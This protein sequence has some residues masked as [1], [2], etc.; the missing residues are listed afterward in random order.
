MRAAVLW[1]AGALLAVAPGLALA[2]IGDYL[3]KPVASLRVEVE[4]RPVSDPRVVGLIET[5][6]GSPLSMLAVRETI[7]HLF[8]LGRY[9][10]VRVE[11]DGVP[12]GVRLTYDLV[13]IHPIEKILFAGP[14]AQPGIDEGRLRRAVVERYGA[15]PQA[16]RRFDL[17]RIV[18]EELRQR[19]YLRAT[20]APTIEIAHAP[21]RAT[22]VFTIEPGV[23]THV[24]TI[25]VV[26]APGVPIPEFLNRLGLR[27]GVSYERDALN[28]RIQEYQKGQWSGGYV[29]AKLAVSTRLDDDDRTA[30]LTL[31]VSRGPR[32]RVVFKG[33]PIARDKHAELV[34]IAEEASADEDLLEDSTN[35]IEEYLRGLGYRDAAAPHERDEV[36][37][38]LIITFT[39]TRGPLYRVSEVVISGNR[40]ESLAQLEPRFAVH[41]GQPFAQAK[42][43]ADVSAIE[44]F[45]R[46]QGFAA[47]R[48]VPS[49]ELAPTVAG[50][51]VP[52]VVRLAITEGV[53]TVVGSVHVRGNRSV[54]EVELVRG[55]GLQPGS[56]FFLTQMAIDRDAL[57]LQYAN[58]GYQSATIASNP[59]IDV[60]GG[61]ANVVFT[62]NEGPQLIVDHVL[63]VGNMRTK[64][65]TIER[66]L[67][68]KAG[69][70]VGLAAV[71]ESQRRLA[72]L[73]LFR[74]VRIMQV[75]HG[76]EA[77]RDLVVTIEESPVTTVGYG[78][79][80]E[81]LQRARTDPDSGAAVEHLEFSPR[82][83]FE[84]GRRNLFG[85][86]RSIN[87]FMRISLRPDPGQS[88]ADTRV[89]FSEYRVFGA[90]REPRLFGTAADA[91]L[92]GTIEQQSRS[93]FNF[94]RQVFSVELGRRVTPNVSFSG[95]YQIQRSELFDQGAIAEEDKL[96]IDRLFPQ[97]L[98]S[99]FSASGVQST[100]DD[101]VNPTMGHY[102]SA[103]GQLAARVIGSEVGF[104]KSY[105]TAQ[106]FRTLPRSRGTVLATSARLG[107]AYGFPR[108]I[109][110][111]H[112]QG[113]PVPGPD[114]A[115]GFDLVL[116]L[117]ASER[118]FAGGDTTVRGFALDQLGTPATL[119]SNGFAIGGNAVLILNA[120]LRVPIHGSIGVVG[121]VDAGNVFARTSDI[122]LGQ[123]RSTLGFGVRYKSP[124]GPIRVDIG[125]KT[126]RNE[127]VPGRFESANS[128]HISLGQAF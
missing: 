70:P 110:R 85:K 25:D 117:P 111:T 88:T 87:L 69:D 99:S 107:M 55:L 19:G 115:P 84:V 48:V 60:G 127:L 24:G 31:T 39:V 119:D 112:E 78:G 101:A 18:E 11:A 42:L 90:F 40:F 41:K 66:E 16:G 3:G 105:L 125:F 109:E 49:L 22:L 97:V 67:Q 63:I 114:G 89:G 62:V 100:K 59:G 36:N 102:F 23:R 64:T 45:N 29:Q 34:P 118:F 35:R 4:G 103:N 94:S 106:A 1:L 80:L 28:A 21:D 37:G 56:P 54:P 91:F 120:E 17:A 61:L 7:T 26:G 58:R 30:H 47:V 121:F 51:D 68:V 46:R 126:R 71:V 83:F 122:D 50:T 20:I 77:R 81:A 124:V 14:M 15:S 75:P 6:L 123:L 79:G 92:T 113:D 128:L 53:R 10:D 8:S 27:T 13:P 96:L 73:G 74:R 72:E 98:L 32:V 9:E 44:A 116:D 43:Q 95:N 108:T 104:F 38:E 33:D 65:E 2:D 82:A 93:N 86:N 76:D 57:Q 12:E 5:R 52:V